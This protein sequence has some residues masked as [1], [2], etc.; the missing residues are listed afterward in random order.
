MHNLFKFNFEPYAPL[1]AFYESLQIETFILKYAKEY[2][3]KE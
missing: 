3:E 2:T 1:L